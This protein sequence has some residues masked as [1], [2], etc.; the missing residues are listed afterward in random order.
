MT[1]MP[2]T[3]ISELRGLIEEGRRRPVDREPGLRVDRPALVDRLADDVH[4]PAERLRSDRD[5]DRPAGVGHRLATHQAVGGIHGDR[6]H[7]TFAQFL[8]DLQHQ[9][10]PLHVDVQGV[11]N[12]R[13]L[14]LVEAD[15]DDRAQ[16]LGYG[17]YGVLSV[18]LRK[19][20]QRSPSWAPPIKAL[21]RPR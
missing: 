6:A 11:E 7:H 16:D 5:G 15:V 3:R 20:L 9:P 13:K 21:R 8:G 19:L 14:A 1:L 17:A 18:H 2:V 12:E 10:A 4:D